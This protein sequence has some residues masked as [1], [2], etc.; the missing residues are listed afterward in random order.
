ML[1][2]SKWIRIERSCFSDFL[3]AAILA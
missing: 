3:V 1:A 2:A